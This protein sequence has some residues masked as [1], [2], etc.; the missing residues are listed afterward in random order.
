AANL[1]PDF[2]AQVHAPKKL[3]DPFN[4]YL[5]YLKHSH[6]LV[7]KVYLL[8]KTGGFNDKGSREAI[9]FTRERLAAG[10]QMLLDLWYTAWLESAK[11]EMPAFSEQPKKPGPG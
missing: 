11:K 4:D 6:E 1:K 8:E 9:A 2:S 10:S 7:D 5:T 3:D